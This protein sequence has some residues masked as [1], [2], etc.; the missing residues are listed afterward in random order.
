MLC[1][2]DWVER[3][4]QI[5]LPGSLSRLDMLLQGL[6]GLPAPLATLA[7]SMTENAEA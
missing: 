7:V 1:A 5:C 6:V 2:R 4:S 3:A